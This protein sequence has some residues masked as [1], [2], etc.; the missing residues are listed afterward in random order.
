[1]IKDN[2]HYLREFLTEFHHT[3]SFF[4]TSQKAAEQLA[5]PLSGMRAPKRILELGPGTGSVTLPILSKMIP[6]DQL[7][8]CE[9]NPRFM[10]LLKE[11]LN[12]KQTYIKHRQNVSFHLCPAQDLPEDIKFDIIVCSLPF[13]NFDLETV[14]EIFSKL[15][16]ISTPETVMTYYQYI[17]LRSIRKVVGSPKDKRRFAE[18][19]SFFEA[20]CERHKTRRKRVWFNMLPI[21]VYTMK[22][23]A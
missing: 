17:G 5:N 6:G 21:N 8:I 16:R 18:L 12:T 1:M 22:L 20:T 2:I 4:P 19:D 7:V 14:E 23:A 13:L 15:Q 9:I 3:G 11:K 10:D